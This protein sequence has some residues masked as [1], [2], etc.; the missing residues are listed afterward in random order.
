MLYWHLKH[1]NSKGGYHV[2]GRGR[3]VAPTYPFVAPPDVVVQ[4]KDRAEANAIARE[5]NKT[6]RYYR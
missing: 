4:A 6:V 1:L 3:K 2:Y 5:R